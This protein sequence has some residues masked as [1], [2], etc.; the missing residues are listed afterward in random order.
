ERVD[1][2]E[3]DGV[4]AD[5]EGE[6]HDGKN[7]EARLA[8]QLAK[9]VT[10]FFHGLAG[11]EFSNWVAHASRVLATASSCRELFI[12]RDRARKMMRQGKIVLARRRNQ[13][14]RRARY[15]D[16]L[17][18]ASHY[19]VLRASSGF[20]RLARRAGMRHAS[21]ATRIRNSAAT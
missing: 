13:R 19:S 1:R 11:V 4:R 17:R 2:R 14:A 5:A 10:E 16:L 21:S 20:T 15:P 18:R 7:G 12:W 9:C 3:E 8:K 6:R